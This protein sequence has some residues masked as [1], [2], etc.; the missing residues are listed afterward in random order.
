MLKVFLSIFI[1]LFVTNCANSSYNNLPVAPP[2]QEKIL[3]D[4]EEDVQQAVDLFEFTAEDENSSGAKSHNGIMSKI[5]SQLKGKVKRE[6]SSRKGKL[7]AKKSKNAEKLA[8]VKK[9][10]GYKYA[11]G[12]VRPFAPRYCNRLFYLRS[13]RR[14]IMTQCIIDTHKLNFY[15]RFKV[16][17]ASNKTLLLNAKYDSCTSS[18]TVKKIEKKIH[19][20]AS[21]LQQFNGL[22][23]IMSP[24][25]A[26]KASN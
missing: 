5:V 9:S 4:L 25:G 16:K 7:L 6:S 11:L 14:K 12:V 17:M 2:G 1:L 3:A 20:A 18:S 21:C 19:V 26:L 8:E 23:K 15:Q 24:V 10:I 22:H 13:L